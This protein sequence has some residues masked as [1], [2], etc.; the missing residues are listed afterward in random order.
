[1]NLFND[2]NDDYFDFGIETLF[3][4]GPD[5][6]SM[7]SISPHSLVLGNSSFYDAVAVESDRP[8]SRPNSLDIP[9]QDQASEMGKSAGMRCQQ[10]SEKAVTPP[11]VDK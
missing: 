9:K 8:R 2:R 11:S 10:H 7:Y 5:D 1:M 6:N 3:A 4:T